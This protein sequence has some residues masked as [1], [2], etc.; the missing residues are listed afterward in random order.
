MDKSSILKVI[1]K[2]IV[3]ITAS[4]I[5]LVVIVACWP[6]GVVLWAFDKV[7]M[8]DP[9]IY[10]LPSLLAMVV[11]WIFLSSWIDRVIVFGGMG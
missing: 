2:I 9:F 11:W 3:V 6:F 10:G 4:P 1:A 8:G 5:A 7:D